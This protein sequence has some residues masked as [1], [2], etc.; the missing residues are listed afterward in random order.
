MWV[1]TKHIKTCSP[2]HRQG[3]ARARAVRGRDHLCWRAWSSHKR[4]ART[5]KCSPAPAS[6]YS[7]EMKCV[8]T[9]TGRWAFRATF[10][11]GNHRSPSGGWTDKGRCAFSGQ[12]VSIKKAWGMVQAPEGW[13]VTWAVCHVRFPTTRCMIPFIRNPEKG[14]TRTEELV[15]AGGRGGFM[16]EAPG[17]RGWWKHPGLIVVVPQQSNCPLIVEECICFVTSF[18][19]YQQRPIMIW[20]TTL[21]AQIQIRESWSLLPS[22]S[23]PSPA[24]RNTSGVRV[25]TRES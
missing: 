21:K 16:W 12:T 2:Q 23:D 8:S 19:D 3:Q 9:G 13:V 24:P 14:K 6:L 18:N 20:Q 15:V 22:E 1:P 11:N 10:S 4:P 5:C 25:R 17:G 7:W